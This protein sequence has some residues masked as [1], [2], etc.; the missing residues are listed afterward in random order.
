MIH[1]MDVLICIKQKYL[2]FGQQLTMT[3]LTHFWEQD[4][5]TH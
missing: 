5:S 1:Y 4:F 2:S 3:N